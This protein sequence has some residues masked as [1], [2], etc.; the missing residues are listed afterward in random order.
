MARCFSGI[1]AGLLLGMV[2]ILAGGCRKAPAHRSTAATQVT[3]SKPLFLASIAPL[4]SI[5]SALAGERAEVRVL[6][7]AGASPHAFEPRPSDAALAQGCA[8]LFYVDPLLDGWA[9]RLAAP[10]KIVVFEY[11]PQADRLPLYAADQ[12]HAQA[13]GASADSATDPHF[14]T[15]PRIVARILP[16]LAADL[17]RLDPAG[18]DEYQRKA[19]AFAAELESLDA[20]L[21]AQL[22]RYAGEPV[23]L[24]HPSMRYFLKAYGLELAAVVEAAPGKEPSPADLAELVSLVRARRIRA[25]F[26][27]PQLPPQAVEAIAEAAGVQVYVLDPLG[28]VGNARGYENML[29]DNAGTLA[30]AFQ[31][32]AE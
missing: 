23:V 10:A 1:A 19:K 30:R 18:A 13:N 5:L 2:L 6:L 29:R 24:F 27:E 32:P 25:I 8:G 22:A 3:A 17:G 15:D 28:P 11:V 7:P 20:E 12:R 9:A 4:G 21:R 14:W 31:A 16:A 26:S